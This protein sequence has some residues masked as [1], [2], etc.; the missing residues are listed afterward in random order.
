MARRVRNTAG[1]YRRGPVVLR[2]SQ[3]PAES[4]S[5]EFLGTERSADW[6]DLDPWRVLRIQSDFVEGFGA[7]AEIGPA[8]SVFGSARTARN[9]QE[10]LWGETIGRL[11][12]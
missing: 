11:L 3:V 2:G 5:A 12:V 10:Y 4:S 1:P 9:P 8:I 7:L 6:L